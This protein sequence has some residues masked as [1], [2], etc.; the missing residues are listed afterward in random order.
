MTN[1]DNSGLVYQVPSHGVYIGERIWQSEKN[2]S[3]Y[4]DLQKDIQVGLHLGSI[5]E[6][7]QRYVDEVC[8]GVPWQEPED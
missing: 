5:E 1:Y 4:F 8:N 3:K 7:K 6:M 2:K